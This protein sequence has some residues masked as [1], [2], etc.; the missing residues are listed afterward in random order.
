MLSS[1][2]LAFPDKIVQGGRGEKWL[3]KNLWIILKTNYFLT[4]EFPHVFNRSHFVL[5]KSSGSVKTISITAVNDF[6]PLKRYILK[7]RN[8]FI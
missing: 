6:S 5:P 3:L 7:C 4:W 8:L 2:D 1:R